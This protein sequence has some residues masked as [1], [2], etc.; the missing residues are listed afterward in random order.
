[1]ACARARFA[2][3]GSPQRFN[4]SFMLYNIFALYVYQ[5]GYRVLAATLA[6]V[7]LLRLGGCA[8][9]PPTDRSGEAAAEADSLPSR[10]DS[11][12]RGMVYDCADA[13][14]RFSTWEQSDWAGLWLPP[15]FDRPYERLSRVPSASGVRY[16]GNGITVWTREN[17][18]LLEIDGED[19]SPCALD[20]YAS[21]WE[22]AKLRGVAFRGVGNE[23]GW[24]LEIT[25][26]ERIR[27]LLDYGQRELVLPDPGPQTDRDAGRSVYRIESD[28]LGVTITLSAE[29]CPDTMDDRTYESTVVLRVGDRTYR[30][31][32]R[33]LF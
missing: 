24:L 29:P 14:F 8:P 25:S 23:P 2:H 9:T 30:G 12:G 15:S 1:M 3:L 16:E 32:G 33:A 10:V 26:G 28:T 4:I 22:D 18:A 13:G 20:W 31:C 17:E 7:I 6:V 11:T 27:L 21:V 19:Y 5:G